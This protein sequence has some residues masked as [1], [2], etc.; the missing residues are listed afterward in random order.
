MKRYRKIG[1]SAPALEQNVNVLIAILTE[2]SWMKTIVSVI[3]ARGRMDGDSEA[4]FAF[5]YDCL[6]FLYFTEGVWYVI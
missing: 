4:G 6:F 3:K 2:S 5:V 1:E